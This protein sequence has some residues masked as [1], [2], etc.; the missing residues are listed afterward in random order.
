MKKRKWLGSVLN[1]I[2][3]GLGNI[4]ARK[5]TKGII[6]FHLFFV[7]LL[8][9]RFIAYNFSIFF[10]WAFTIIV[11]LIYLIISG[12]RE[13]DKDKI[14]SKNG[15]DRWYSYV[16][17]IL[18]YIFLSGLLDMRA[19][20]RLSPINFASIPTPAMSP[21]LQVGDRLAFK[22]IDKLNRNDISIFW[23][24]IDTST[25]FVKRCVGLP[26]DT[27]QIDASQV[28]INKKKLNLNDVKIKYLVKTNGTPLNFE[29]LKNYGYES[30]DYYMPN[31]NEYHLFLTI[32]QVAHL[33]SLSITKSIERIT[34][35]KD[36]KEE[37]IYPEDKN[38]NADYYGP[39]YIPKEGDQIKLT[40]SNINLYL[41]CIEYENQAVTRTEKGL[42]VD[43]ELITSYTFK[44]NYYFM[45]G[46]NRHN[47]LDSRYWGLLPEKW[48]IG[49]VMYV[50]WAE[51]SDRIGETVL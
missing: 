8:G 4:Y 11:F 24:P 6:L 38:W 10:I 9:G 51:N 35:P 15:W 20:D 42:Q 5:I 1:I 45:M 27:L 16:I 31:P 30:A 32:D 50:Y 22:K 34:F 28:I 39:I 37:I 3:P 19:L 43:G 18:G 7:V 46:D 48:V 12:Y 17:I 2:M 44:D 21:A 25:M 33:K 47:S 40:S 26:G 29:R 23:F 36:Q 13:V 14:Y 49:K 41:K